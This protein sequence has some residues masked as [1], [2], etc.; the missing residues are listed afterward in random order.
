MASRSSSSEPA[1][2]VYYAPDGSE[3]PVTGEVS[4]VEAVELRSR[5]YSTDKPK[6]VDPDASPALVPDAGPLSGAAEPPA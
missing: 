5:G 2:T 6:G 4:P 3:Y 1:V